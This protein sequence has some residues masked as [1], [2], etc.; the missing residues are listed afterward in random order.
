MQRLTTTLYALICACAISSTAFAGQD[1]DQRQAATADGDVEIANLRGTIRVSGWD[2]KEVHVKGSLDD[3]LREF[4][5][6]VE[7]HRTV[8]HIK[9][10]DQQHHS[11]QGTDLEI[12]VPR[13]SRLEMTGVSSEFQIGDI[14]G[15]VDAK[16]VSGDITLDNVQRRARVRTVSGDIEATL[17]DADLEAASISGNI[18]AQL[19][20]G[21]VQAKSI[22]GDIRVTA[23]SFQELQARA[24][25]GDISV[26][27]NIKPRGEVK[28][29]G[30][31]GDLRL[32][33][34]ADVSAR[35]SL[36]AGPGGDIRNRLSDDRAEESMVGGGKL[37]FKRGDGDARV[38]MSTASGELRLGKLED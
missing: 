4:V 20:N 31:S 15:D 7:G 17:G 2:E 33:L 10:K 16:T 36:A 34:Q 11:G 18:R 23:K 30:V 29:S 38:K 24:V 25:S 19:G 27:G 21:D 26:A 9:L 35:F 37:E 5:F 12:R 1:V 22:S 14:H 13:A 28:L 6:K 32:Y 8:I 3:Q